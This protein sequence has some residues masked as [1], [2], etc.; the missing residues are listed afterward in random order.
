MHDVTLP[1]PSASSLL[2]SSL[3]LVFYRP[4]CFACSAWTHLRRL[5]RFFSGSVERPV[6][7][8]RH[9]VEVLRH[10]KPFSR[11]ATGQHL[12]DGHRQQQAD[13]RKLHGFF[14]LS[15]FYFIFL[16]LC[17][18]TTYCTH[19]HIYIYMSEILYD[20]SKRTRR[21]K[22]HNGC[23]CRSVMGRAAGNSDIFASRSSL[24]GQHTF[25]QQLSL[26]FDKQSTRQGKTNRHVGNCIKTQTPNERTATTACE[27]SSTHM[28][29]QCR[30]VCVRCS[31]CFLSLP[32]VPPAPTVP[33]TSRNMMAVFCGLWLP[34]QLLDLKYAKQ[35]E[36]EKSTADKTTYKHDSPHLASRYMHTVPYTT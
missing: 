29:S 11:S 19:I 28:R 22:Q 25:G 6:S 13:K 1:L 31:S 33:S 14:G 8:L 34:G 21:N 26:I 27:W 2:G 12:P 20:T 16:S 10:V 35:E 17:S 7:E 23:V 9:R 15:R 32:P 18:T 4:P 30:N 3:P 5:Q 24:E 36:I